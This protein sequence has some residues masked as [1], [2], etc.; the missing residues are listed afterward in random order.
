M[1]G[2]FVNGSRGMIQRIVCGLGITFFCVMGAVVFAAENAHKETTEKTTQLIIKNEPE[3]NTDGAASTTTNTAASTTADVTINTI[4][5]NAADRTKEKL[6]YKMKET[7]RE[8]VPPEKT[9]SEGVSGKKSV[10]RGTSHAEPNSEQRIAAMVPEK[11]SAQMAIAQVF[12]RM[13]L[14]EQRG[15]IV[16][17]Q[18]CLATEEFARLLDRLDKHGMKWT[19]ETF[20][21][22]V[23]PIALEAYTIRDIRLVKHRAIVWYVH[24]PTDKDAIPEYLFLCAQKEADGW[25][26]GPRVHIRAGS[27]ADK[28]ETSTFG[29]F[30]DLPG[31]K[32][33]L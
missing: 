2:V 7:P 26:I 31:L 15:D 25:R 28:P 33:W 32:G 23:T 24:T 12:Q 14:A 17:Y 13:S 18:A 19:A 1:G 5:N 16:G 27:S 11:L 30:L 8:D 10:E 9:S 21:K 29:S 20:K 6:S 3:K 4:P 22:L